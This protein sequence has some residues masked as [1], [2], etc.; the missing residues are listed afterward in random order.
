M[1]AN[2]ILPSQG[3]EMTEFP[4][5]F[6]PTYRQKKVN[7]YEQCVKTGL[8]KTWYGTFLQPSK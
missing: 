5:E 7:L 8:F 3:T 1:T 4:L 6:Q 2:E